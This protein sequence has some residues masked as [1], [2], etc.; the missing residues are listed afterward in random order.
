MVEEPSD[1]S[2][3]YGKVYSAMPMMDRF[4][5]AT[6]RREEGSGLQKSLVEMALP[7]TEGETIRTVPSL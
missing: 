2:S 1:Q 3:G 7:R 6:L 5:V 4:Q